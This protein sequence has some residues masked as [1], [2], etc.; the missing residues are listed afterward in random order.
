ME[1]TKTFLIRF[2]LS[3]KDDI[4]HIRQVIG[5]SMEKHKVNGG[6]SIVLKDLSGGEGKNT[7]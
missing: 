3:Q 4:E 6:R 1:T 5:G 7:M 2:I